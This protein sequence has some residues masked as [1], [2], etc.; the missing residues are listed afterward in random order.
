M[1]REEIIYGPIKSRR[2]GNS[3]GINILPEKG[4]LC[5]F[6]CIYCECGWNK[7][8]MEDKRLPSPD[9]LKRALR[10]KLEGCTSSRERL[11][12]ITFAG[13]GES[14]LHPDFPEM[15]DIVLSLRD[16]FY[17]G[18]RVVVLTN[19]TCIGKDK[20]F[21]AL[22]RVDDPVLKIDAPTSALAGL[23]NRPQGKYDPQEV[24][25]WMKRFEGDFI[26]QTMFLRCD[27]FDS[28]SPEVLEGWMDLV[29]QTKPRKLMLYT[30]ARPTPQE[31]LCKI[32]PDEIRDLVKPLFEEGYDIQI[33]G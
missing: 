24:A 29:R 25:L 7:D 26:L 33:N 16:E 11:D 27:T 21:E 19:A 10:T 31:G 2:F 8:G 1:I 15:V 9:E 20:V 3:L 23:I 17:P 32:G 5:N 6:D 22:R 13:D 18:C 28:S 14:T 12:V 4:K 30:I